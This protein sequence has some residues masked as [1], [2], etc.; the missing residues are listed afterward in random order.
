M[1]PTPMDHRAPNV[2]ATQPTNGEPSGVAPR[3]TIRYRDITRPRIAGVVD[4]CRVAFAAVSIVRDAR[5]TGMQA[6]ANSS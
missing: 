6:S 1:E 5:P 2:S 4:I 3:K